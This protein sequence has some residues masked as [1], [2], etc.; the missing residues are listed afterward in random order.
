MLLGLVFTDEVDPTA[1]ATFALAFATVA[2]VILTMRSLRYTRHALEQTR[3][4]VKLSQRQVE[5]GHRP[6][7]VPL[8]DATRRIKPSRPDSP[9]M[10]PQLM[11][12]G[13]LWVP[14]E[15]IGSG[16][17]LSIEVS[18]K[19]TSSSGAEVVGDNDTGGAIAGLGVDHLIAVEFH[20]SGLTSVSDFR[21]SIDYRDVAGKLWKTQARYAAMSNRYEE[22][23]ISSSQAA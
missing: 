23:A 21:M 9:S 11:S 2:T 5:E 17:A 22:I 1:L 3:E 16:P 18:L 13:L 15:N 4:E 12:S 7:V 6:V 20:V 19:L 8:L 10:G 14:I